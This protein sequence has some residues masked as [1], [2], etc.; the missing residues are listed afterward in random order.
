MSESLNVDQRVKLRIG[1]M[2]IY[3]IGLEKEVEDLRAAMPPPAEVDP[4]PDAGA[5]PTT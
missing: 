3:I 2:A 4:R 1:E 5:N